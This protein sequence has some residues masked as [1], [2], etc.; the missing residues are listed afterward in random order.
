MTVHHDAIAFYAD[1]ELAIMRE[2]R[3]NRLHAAKRGSIGR[4]ARADL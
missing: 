1:D 3:I 4:A 2:E